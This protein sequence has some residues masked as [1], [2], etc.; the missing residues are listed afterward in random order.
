V[1]GETSARCKVGS[2]TQAADAVSVWMVVAEVESIDGEVQSLASA[3]DGTCASNVL[4]LRQFARTEAPRPFLPDSIFDKS[5]MSLITPA[6]RCPRSESSPRKLTC[7]SAVFFS[8]FL[9]ELCQISNIVQG[10]AQFVAPVARNS[11][12]YARGERR[13]LASLP[14]HCLFHSRFFVST[15]VF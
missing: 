3:S 9:K 5:R 4:Q 13:L 2:S 11:L 14:M 7:W 15:S 12:L 6:G 10:R 8:E 1:F